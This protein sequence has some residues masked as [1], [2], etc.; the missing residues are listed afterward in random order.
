MYSFFGIMLETA[1]VG[2]F[3]N[4]SRA[5]FTL[6]K[7]CTSDQ[8]HSSTESQKVGFCGKCS[9]LLNERNLLRLSR[10]W[11]RQLHKPI[12]QFYKGKYAGRLLE[13]IAT[14]KQRNC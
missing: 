5:N 2:K 14:R 7:T 3:I 1:D 11:Q 8:Y 6:K 9:L 13:Q 10:S 4:Q 12:V